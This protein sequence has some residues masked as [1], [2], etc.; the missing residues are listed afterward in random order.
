MRDT[1]QSI[2]CGLG[3][4]TFSACLPL[5]GAQTA[6]GV[7]LAIVL[8][9]NKICAA[10]GTWLSNPLTYVPI[11]W[12]NYNVGLLLLPNVT[13][14]DRLRWD[15]IDD[16]LAKMRDLS[17]PLGLGSLVN[18]VVVGVLVYGISLWLLRRRESSIARRHRAAALRRMHRHK[19]EAHRAALSSGKPSKIV[20]YNQ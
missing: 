18:G 2:A 8:R 15:S 6:I 14:P 13:A 5:F 7:V 17:V 20:E 12:L 3:V 10:F 19:L 11:F 1:P 9:G 4:G 16:M